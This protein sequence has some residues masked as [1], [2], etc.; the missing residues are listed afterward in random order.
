MLLTEFQPEGLFGEGAK[1]EDGRGFT[2]SWFVDANHIRMEF[3]P[4][5]VEF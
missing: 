1:F 4:K 5:G 2:E 3:V